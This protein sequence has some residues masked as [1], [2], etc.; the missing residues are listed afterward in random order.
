M[1]S[2]QIPSLL[3]IRMSPGS[4][5]NVKGEFSKVCF[6]PD[7][8]IPGITCLRYATGAGCAGWLLVSALGLI[9]VAW[10]WHS[11]AGSDKPGEGDT[12]SGGPHRVQQLKCFLV[13]N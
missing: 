13:V 3:C 7:P 12:K 4:G 5:R 6:R 10:V 11:W 2:E 1:I 9:D 8:G